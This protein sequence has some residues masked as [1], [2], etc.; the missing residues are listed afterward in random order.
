MVSRVAPPHEGRTRAKTPLR[1]DC[2]T[3]TAPA[4]PLRHERHLKRAHGEDTARGR[5]TG[6]ALCGE[7]S[8]ELQAREDELRMASLLARWRGPTV[9]NLSLIHI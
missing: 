1:R 7:R 5:A 9:L 2:T 4:G 6:G 8:D 3:K